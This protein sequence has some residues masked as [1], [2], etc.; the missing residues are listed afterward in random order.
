M[1]RK[2]NGFTLVELVMVI[3]ILGILAAFAFPR[4][5]ALGIEAR[6][7]TVNAQPVVYAALPCWCTAWH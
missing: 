1:N 6:A 2:E 7:S 5:A 4:F 3:T